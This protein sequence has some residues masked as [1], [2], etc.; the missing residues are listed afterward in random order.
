MLNVKIFKGR[1]HQLTHAKMFYDGI[2]HF[3]NINAEI[4]NTIDKPVDLLVLWGHRQSHIIDIQRKD[5]KPYLVMERA[6]L[7]D[8]FKWV[9]LGFNGLNNRADFCNS[10][11]TTS[12]RWNE[13]F[14]DCIQD[15]QDVSDRDTILVIG[16][17]KGDAAHNHIDIVEWYR[18]A[19]SYYNKAGYNVRFRAHP[20][21]RD[22]VIK[23]L[24]RMSLKF[25]ID[26]NKSLEDNFSNVRATVSYNSNASLLSVLAGIPTVTCDIGAMAYDVTSHDFN[27]IDYKPD[28]TDWCNKLAY[29]QW[30]PEEILSGKAWIH[31]SNFLK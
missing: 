31:L 20:L 28:R 22:D 14:S 2:K 1:E 7:K 4:V 21:D 16:Q 30:L 9:S 10:D 15:W 27:D 29:T 17:V 13:H 11:I 5:N 26:T 8:R 25:E 6:Y 3:E 23:K 18:E 12:D 19:I 24:K